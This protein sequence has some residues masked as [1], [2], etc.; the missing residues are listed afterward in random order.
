[1]TD[2]DG[3]NIQLSEADTK[4]LLIEPDLQSAGWTGLSMRM[5][6]PI[7][8]GRI[9]RDGQRAKAEFADYVLYHKNSS[10]NKPIAV[11]EAKKNSLVLG[12]GREQ[13]IKYAL[14]LDARFAYTSNGT[15]FTEIDVKTNAERSFGRGE[16]PTPDVLWSMFN[17]NLMPSDGLEKVIDEPLA[18][19]DNKTPRYYQ[20][21]AINRTVEA[22]A[23]G[24][25]RILLVMATGTGKTYTAA[26]ICWKLWKTRQ[27]KKILYLA[28]R[29]ILIGQTI[30][31][32]FK[33]FKNV[34]TKISN[35][36]MDT[37][38]ELYFAL[39]Q[40]LSDTRRQS[41]DEDSF[42]VLETLKKSF[43]PSFFDLIIVDE[44][45]RGSARADSNWKK[46][47]T[48]FGSATQIGMT[49]TPKETAKISN[50][51]YFGEP[52]FT[53][54]LKDG[55]DDGYLA[56]YR[57]VRVNLD[58]DLEGY[59]PEVG[60]LDI[61]GNEVPDE[62]YEKND[63]DRKI[64]IDE[65][66]NLVAK[67]I[68][69]FLKATDRM[70]KT[71]VFC[72]DINHAE[73]MAVALRELNKDKCAESSEYIVRVTGDNSESEALVDKFSDVDCPY[74]VICTTSDL[75]STGVD[76][77]T[78]KL[79]VLDNIFGENGM[80]K[81]KQIIGRG[82]RIREDHDKFTFTILDFRGASRLFADPAFDGEPTK[83]IVIPP[84]G[85]IPPTIIDGGGEGTPVVPLPPDRHL[86]KKIH[87]NGV[88]VAISNERVSFYDVNGKLV[89]ES[90]TDYTKHKF[91]QKCAT[92]DDFLQLW[93]DSEKREAIK[94]ELAIEGVSLDELRAQV[95]IDNID[96]F[97][98][99]CHVVFDQKPLT[100][101]DRA[102]NV[103]QKPYFEKYSE[104]AKRVL[105][106]LVDKYANGAID[107]FDDMDCLKLP[108]LQEEFGSPVNIV[109]LFG[110][111]AGWLQATQDLQNAMYRRAY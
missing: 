38:Y 48:Y 72:V 27:K 107:D 56:P 17:D 26:Q 66:T 31:N 19:I 25:Q 97:D 33:P 65:R 32:D 80:I 8:A 68:T 76:C 57:V 29:N 22:I 14:K 45:H 23:K 55:I 49:A 51:D 50:I 98:L 42:D 106:I 85:P 81:F 90:Y 13:A 34:A 64:I 79:I 83:V 96:D 9:I 58:R 88:E 7:S 11:I 108:E 82:T 95:G 39:Y 75:M 91:L 2:G 78:C 86:V 6:V 44:C 12:T 4:R 24:Q 69:D 59:R 102:R 36:K 71:I 101:S 84:E 30:S 89:T 3:I 41:N 53:Y 60:K 105:E 20:T 61:E 70:A 77:K 10:A 110:G 99:L 109:S 16:F 62:I 94:E 52:L 67:R 103:R 111:K 46:I 43:K 1:M 37:S 28:D 54:S 73:R 5:E 92:L 35:K 104:K 40:Q 100:R 47:L 93:T 63:F 87:V 74:P 21:I 18:I 15:G